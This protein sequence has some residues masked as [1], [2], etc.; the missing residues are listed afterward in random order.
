MADQTYEEYKKIEESLSDAEKR[1]YVSRK[2]ILTVWCGILATLVVVIDGIAVFM[3][4]SLPEGFTGLGL[5]FG[6][7]LIA[8]IGGNV[9]QKVAG[10]KER[11]Q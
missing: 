2:W 6:T 5:M 8:Y 7:E 9:V 4:F 10:K 1:K 11:E 3:D